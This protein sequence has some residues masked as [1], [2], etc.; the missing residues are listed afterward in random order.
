MS[1]WEIKRA[2]K[3]MGRLTAQFIGVSFDRV[4]GTF[5]IWRNVYKVDRQ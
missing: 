2:K 3:K 4:D 5:N 1:K